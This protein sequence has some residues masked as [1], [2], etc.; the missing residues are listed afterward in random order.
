VV[1]QLDALFQPQAI[2]G[3]RYNAQNQ[4]EIDTEDTPV[5]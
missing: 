3:A 1:A 4:A 2:H 5:A